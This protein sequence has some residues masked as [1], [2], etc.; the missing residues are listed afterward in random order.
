MSLTGFQ[1]D[2]LTLSWNGG[3]G[4]S[5]FLDGCGSRTSALGRR[6]CLSSQGWF[7]CRLSECWTMTC[8]GL[9]AFSLRFQQYSCRLGHRMRILWFYCFLVNLKR[10]CFNSRTLLLGGCFQSYFE[11]CSFMNCRTGHKKSGVK[12]CSCFFRWFQ[13]SWRLLN[14][15]Q[16]H[17]LYD[18]YKS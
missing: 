17:C 1:A 8:L 11:R 14:P 18:C 6:A 16:D 12:N 5:N 3:G 13:R 4:S 10:N 7:L 2:W 15:S 9:L